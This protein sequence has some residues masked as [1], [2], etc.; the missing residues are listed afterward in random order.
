MKA[1]TQSRFH[2]QRGWDIRI[3]NWHDSDGNLW[4]IFVD[5]DTGKGRIDIEAIEIR[6]VTGG[7][8]LT[9]EILSELPL[10]ELVSDVI[11]GE[12]K[13]RNVARKSPSVRPHSGRRHTDEELQLVALIYKSAYR[14][15]RPVQQAVADGLKISTSTAAK[16]IM[17]ARKRG[18]IPDGV[19]EKSI[20]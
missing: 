13:I 19:N 6:P 15:H 12:Q 9:Q 4:Q 14:L 20:P 18:L 1:R 10:A 16:R 5:V 8:P 11:E 7:Y 2:A 17:A 3:T